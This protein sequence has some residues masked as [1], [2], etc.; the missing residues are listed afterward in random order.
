MQDEAS[1][2]YGRFNAE[3][4][5]LMVRMTAL[6]AASAEAQDSAH[7]FADSVDELIEYSLGDL[8]PSGIV[9]I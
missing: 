3:G 1:R 6:P 5:E 4:I 8:D 2:H 9:G 7:Y